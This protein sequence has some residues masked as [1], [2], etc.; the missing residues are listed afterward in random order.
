MVKL[1]EKEVEHIAKLSRLNLTSKEIEKFASQ[2]SSILEYVE[3][4]GKVD[5]KNIQPIGNITGLF[6]VSREDEVGESYSQEEMLKNA[7]DKKDGYLKVKA[8]LE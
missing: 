5:T 7:P 2:I 6:N 1:S 4:L 3:Q 8:I